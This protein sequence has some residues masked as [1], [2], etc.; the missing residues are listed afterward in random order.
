MNNLTLLFCAILS[1]IFLYFNINHIGIKN[2]TL[3]L[4]STFFSLAWGICSLG[5]Y[6]YSNAVIGD[7]D[8]FLLADHLDSIGQYQFIVLLTIFIAF[9]FARIS[10]KNTRVS[11]PLKFGEQEAPMIRKKMEWLFYLFFLIGTFRLTLVLATVGFDYSA[12]RSSYIGERQAFSS[13]DLNIIRLGSYLMQIAKLYVCLLGIESAIKG[14]KYKKV[15]CAFLL[16]SPFQM[17]FG[18][19]L[20]ILSFFLPF[21]LSY[22]S[23]LYSTPINSLYKKEEFNKAKKLIL[24]PIVL[25]IIF[26]ILKMGEDINIESFAEFST[27]VF[28]SSTS[29]IH[30]NEF[31]DYLGNDY[32]IEYGKNILGYSVTYKNILSHWGDTYNSALVCVPSM[33]PEVYLDFGKYWSIIFYFILFYNI[34]KYAI[35]LF[36][37]A[38]IK[39]F[40]IAIILCIASFQTTSSSMS[41]GIKSFLIAFFVIV[42]Y[43]KLLKLNEYNRPCN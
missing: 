15:F 35:L 20:F 22:F 6:L 8:F 34:E 2:K 25:L 41:Y 37:K 17:S 19:R 29:Y 10:Y 26:Q 4:P 40:L 27:E 7:N 39:S 13:F 36:A 21:F 30:M 23:V 5:G 38:N 43:F 32:N 16:F 12:I 28:Y 11:L 1:F 3:I 33:I 9:W 31:W 14:L 24:L 42:I 18:G